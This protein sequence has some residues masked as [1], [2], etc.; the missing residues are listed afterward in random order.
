MRRPAFL[1]VALALAL[2]AVGS[3]AATQPS[4]DAFEVLVQR[5]IDQRRDL[6]SLSRSAIETRV[7]SQKALLGE[8]RA[9][10]TTGLSPEQ[11]IDHAAIVGQLEGAIFEAEVLQ[12]WERD[13]ELYLQY[14]SL[15]G[16]MDQQGDPATKGRN[17]ATRL[18]ALTAMLGDARANLETPPR[19]FTDNG[20]YQAG[21]W[22]TFLE[23]EVAAFAK[24][25]G[26][27]QT[28]VESAN[29]E[30]LG[31]LADF[32]QFLKVD[33]LSR[34]TGNVAIGKDHYNH[35][36]NVRWY[37]KDD[38]AALLAKGQRAF[39]ETEAQ[40][41]TLAK[42]MRPSAPSWVEAYESLKDDHPPEPLGAGGLWRYISLGRPTGDE[43]KLD[44]LFVFQNG[45]FVQQALN[46]GEPFTTQVAQ[47]HAGTYTVENGKIILNAE[48]GLIVAPGAAAPVAS[49]PNRRHELTPVTGPSRLTLTFR[50]GTVQKFTRVGGAQGRI[51]PLANGALALVDGHFLLVFEEG[52]RAIAGSGTFTQR[53]STL[54]LV[55]ERWLSARDGKV[56]YSKVPLYA[57]LDTT[58]LRLPGEA[59]IRVVGG[60]GR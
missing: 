45:R 13:P 15:A 53:G 20:I 8:V 14:G 42:K 6:G 46:I 47:A 39:A 51:V 2:L 35:I 18:K 37:M 22:R 5:Y 30:A 52:S 36:L 58:S 4:T 32:Q 23:R 55:A 29:A 56:T 60:A 10:S 16:L 50:S 38:A 48:V 31:A 34:S 25:T 9:V 28:E 11:R 1:A 24:T 57:T 3:L 26:P 7:A 12:P 41:T 33:L 43:T 17:V 40:L 49:S 54:R 27:A 59:S 21:E 44:G 19:R